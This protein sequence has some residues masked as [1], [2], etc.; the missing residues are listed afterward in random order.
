VADQIAVTG[1]LESG[2]VASIHFRGGMAHGTNFL[3]E[4]NGTEG[5]LVITC[6]CGLIE[7]FPL[8][9]KEAKGE[10]KELVDL[11]VPELYLELCKMIQLP[12]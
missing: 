12:I 7:M 6:S 10:Q 5:D 4:I 8:Q 2:A 11:P 9:L 1:I 3:W